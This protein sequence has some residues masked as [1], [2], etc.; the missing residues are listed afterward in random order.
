MDPEIPKGIV[1]LDTDTGV[2]EH[3][4]LANQRPLL[5]LPTVHALGLS[6]AEVQERVLERVA[7]VPAG[8]VVRLFLE[9]VV[10][11]QGGRQYMYN[12]IYELLA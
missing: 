3:K 10:A 6:P 9:G 8:A 11:P 1:V 5:T 4:A 12:P 7:A 2:I